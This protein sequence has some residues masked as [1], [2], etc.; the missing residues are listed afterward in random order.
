L[1]SPGGLTFACTVTRLDKDTLFISY[2]YCRTRLS[3]LVSWFEKRHPKLADHRALF[4]AAPRYGLLMGVM[5]LL[6]FALYALSGTRVALLGATT[7][8]ALIA[9]SLRICSS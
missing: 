3:R 9:F 5:V 1:R 7:A 6:P 4:W 8:S 2:S